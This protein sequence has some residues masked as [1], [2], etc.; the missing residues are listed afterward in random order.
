MVGPAG[1]SHRTP[2]AFSLMATPPSCRGAGP[3]ASSKA[4]GLLLLLLLLLP[5]RHPDSEGVTLSQAV[6][7]A[8]AGLGV[9][10]EA[11]PPSPSLLALPCALLSFSPLPYY[12]SL[13]SPR[14]PSST[15]TD[16]LCT[17]DPPSLPSAHGL[18]CSCTAAL[19]CSVSLHSACG[20]RHK[21]GKIVG[22]M[23]APEGKW[24]WQ[25]SVHYGGFHI[26]GGSI[27]NEYWIL[28]AA[29]CFSK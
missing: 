9:V 23:D 12:P 19:T 22:G 3:G 29:H 2:G 21:Q 7:R 27:L 10:P 26:C 24:P 5:H 11:H 1:S 17:A 14:P 8:P 25:V 15:H 13:P 18:A 16:F 6:G 28:S 20:Q 4:S